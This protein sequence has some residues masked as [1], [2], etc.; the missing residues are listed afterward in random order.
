MG[1]L[2]FLPLFTGTIMHRVESELHNDKNQA[3]QLAS[4]SSSQ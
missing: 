4:Y 2:M 1:C 3:S